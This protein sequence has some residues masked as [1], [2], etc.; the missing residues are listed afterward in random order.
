MIP[1]ACCLILNLQGKILL[2]QKP[3]GLWEFPGGKQ[4]PNETLL[5]CAEREI[6]EELNIAVEAIRELPHKHQVGGND[7]HFELILVACS[8]VSGQP[9]LSEHLSAEWFLPEQL[10][11]LSLCPGDKVLWDLYSL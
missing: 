9:R 2:A 4:H 3:T 8:W 1:V 7:R 11:E 5:Q 6:R 10:S